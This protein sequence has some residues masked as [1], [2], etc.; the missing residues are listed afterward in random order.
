MEEAAAAAADFD[1]GFG[2][3]GEDNLSM[4][5]GDFMAFL[6]NEDW[7]EQQHEVRYY[8]PPC[9]NSI[10][11]RV[12]FFF[13]CVRRIRFGARGCWGAGLASVLGFLIASGPDAWISREVSA[14]N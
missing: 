4:P 13:F 7:K 6:D 14:F 12:Y 3:A 10:Y 11:A 2:G 1:G 5:L 9:P 8:S